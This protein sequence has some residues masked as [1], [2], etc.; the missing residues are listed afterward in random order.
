MDNSERIE[1]ACKSLE[2]VQTFDTSTLPREAEL[3]Q[4]FSF[5]EAVPAAVRVINLFQQFPVDA[6]A[7]LPDKQLEKLRLAADAFYN[8]LNQILTF[9]SKQENPTAAHA[10]ILNNVNKQYQQIFDQ[11]NELISYGASRQ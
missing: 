10:S 1:A 6:L 9:D 7:D 4:A 3:G 2:R 11:I 8:V 5:R